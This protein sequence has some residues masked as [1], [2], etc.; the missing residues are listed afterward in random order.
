MGEY[1]VELED[2]RMTPYAE[3]TPDGTRYGWGE[4]P[5]R[6]VVRCRDCVKRSDGGPFTGECAGQDGSADP[7][8]FCAWG[9]PRRGGDCRDGADVPTDPVRSAKR[10]GGV[11]Q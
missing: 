6:Q 3:R 8:G 10:P 5:K 4:M 2:G 11:G 1:I 7:D 9:E